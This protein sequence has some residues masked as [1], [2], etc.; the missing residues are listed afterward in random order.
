M[1]D[2]G[3]MICYYYYSCYLAHAFR[4][5]LIPSLPHNMPTIPTISAGKAG[6]PAAA[7]RRSAGTRAATMTTRWCLTLTMAC[8]Y[9]YVYACSRIVPFSA[10]SSDRAPRCAIPCRRA[11]VEDDSLA[12]Q[13]SS[14]REWD[15]FLGVF[16]CFY[17]FSIGVYIFVF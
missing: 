9:V 1:F 17:W 7:G 13:P 5:P 8:V 14:G 3:A 6:A 11:G 15:R 16:V 2:E 10:G 12:P 4:R